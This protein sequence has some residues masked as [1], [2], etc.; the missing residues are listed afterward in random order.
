MA[1]R[2]AKLDALIELAR[3]GERPTPEAIQDAVD[4]GTSIAARRQAE[5]D[6]RSHLA[7]IARAV[8]DGQFSAADDIEESLRFTLDPKAVR[9]AA[10]EGASKIDRLAPTRSPQQRQA[11]GRINAA[12]REQLEAIMERALQGKAWRERDA[13]KLAVAE[14]ITDAELDAFKGALREKF[15]DVQERRG[16][17]NQRDGRHERAADAAN[18][19]TNHVAA[20]L[21]AKVVDA[22]KH[23][24][25][26]LPEDP[27][28]LAALVPRNIG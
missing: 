15:G 25:A 7:D 17:V 10:D 26:D 16:D 21:A 3:A 14:H 18:A 13:E 6:L 8:E 5:R 19:A 1:K 22:P 28:A 9:E 23:D 24:Y 4:V 2:N 20:L 12:A 27:R 11:A